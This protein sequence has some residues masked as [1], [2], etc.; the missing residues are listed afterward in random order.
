M[1]GFCP[2]VRLCKRFC[3]WVWI[4]WDVSILA[5]PLSQPETLWVTSTKKRPYKIRWSGLLFLIWLFICLFYNFLPKKK[6]KQPQKAQ[7][8][9]TS[10]KDE[11]SWNICTCR[12]LWRVRLKWLSSSS[13]RHL[14]KHIIEEVHFVEVVRSL[15]SK[16]YEGHRSLGLFCWKLPYTSI[17]RWWGRY[18]LWWKVVHNKLRYP[19]LAALWTYFKGLVTESKICAW[20]HI[21]K[22]NF[23]QG[24]PCFRHGLTVMT[25]IT[26]ALWV[27]L[28]Y[29]CLMSG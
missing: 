22:V 25:Y 16:R 26:R 9:S 28:V 20:L 23:Y 10:R 18:F 17:D 29:F 7:P 8:Y 3:V 6:K 24:S 4:H 14:Y 5:P 15:R 1:G 2:C 21:I 12:F 11:F 27:C 13:S 19:P